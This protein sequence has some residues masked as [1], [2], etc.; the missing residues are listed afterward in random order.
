M[1]AT[2][3]IDELKLFLARYGGFAEALQKADRDTASRFNIFNVLGVGTREV[4]THSAFLAELLNPEGSH[5]QGNLFLKFFFEILPIADK[6]HE[7]AIEQSAWYVET[8]K[9]TPLGNLDIIVYEPDSRY[10]IVIENKIYAGEQENQLGR[11]SSW[12]QNS[13]YGDKGI[14]LYLTLDGKPSS[15]AEGVHYHG[16]SYRED[17]S[18]WVQ[19]SL[20]FVTAPR[21]CDV[22]SQYLQLIKTL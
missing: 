6:P 12:I 16:I 8:E 15:D 3:N 5:S 11:Y 9:I 21:M 1:N 2:C 7:T 4:K 22:L 13:P 18:S 10:A 17:I 19:K 20:G 14:L